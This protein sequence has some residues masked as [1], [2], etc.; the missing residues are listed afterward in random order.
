MAQQLSMNLGLPAAP[1]AQGSELYAELRIVYSAIKALASAVDSYCGTLPPTAQEE[2]EYTGTS[3]AAALN[4]AS[5]VYVEAFEDIAAGEAVAFS[6]NL[7]RKA[8]VTT[9]PA[10]GIC[11][12]AATAGS[13]VEVMLLGVVASSGFTSGAP[14]YAS[15][16]AGQITATPTA[17]KVGYAI[18]ATTLMWNPEL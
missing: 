4:R 2:M 9:Y 6:G 5:K 18:N 13:L 10:R 12:Q 14:Y 16:T 17:Q 11:T 1:L 8:V 7:A 3:S 15:A